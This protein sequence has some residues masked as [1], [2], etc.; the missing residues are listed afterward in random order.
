MIVNFGKA[1][2]FAL[3]WEGKLSDDLLDRGGRTA[4]GVTQRTYDAWR[5]AKGLEQNDVWSITQGE[6]ADL[7]K[8]RYWAMCRCDLLPNRLDICMFDASVNHGTRKAVQFLQ[9]S[10][11]V[12]DDGEFGPQTM[13]AL[14][15]DE[16]SD[17]LEWVITS[18]LNHRE[19]F[20]AAIVHRDPKQVKFI[21]GWMNRLNDLRKEVGVTP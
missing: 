15:Q 5:K 6:V 20:Y 13:R 12:V 17:R 9:R 16:S 18:Y 4:Y 10:V 8:E 3:R 2:A 14:S 21:K 7:Y 1:L 19:Q 11:G